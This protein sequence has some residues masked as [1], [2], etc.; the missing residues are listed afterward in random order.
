MLLRKWRIG[1]FY[2]I[3]GDRLMIHAALDLRQSPYS[4]RQQLGLI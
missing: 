3:E 4:I 2:V 1:L